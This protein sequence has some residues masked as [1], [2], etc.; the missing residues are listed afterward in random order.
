[1]EFLLRLL[2]AATACAILYG[3][4]TAFDVPTLI[5]KNLNVRPEVLKEI[6]ETVVEDVIKHATGALDLAIGWLFAWLIPRRRERNT[7]TIGEIQTR[8]GISE[9]DRAGL[10]DADCRLTLLRIMLFGTAAYSIAALLATAFIGKLT[11]G[12]AVAHAWYVGLS[13]VAVGFA[14]GLVA[15]RARARTVFA[16][17][18]RVGYV[19][20]LLSQVAGVTCFLPYAASKEWFDLLG[21]FP[22]LGEVRLLNGLLIFRLIVLP[23]VGLFAAIFGHQLGSIAPKH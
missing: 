21:T 18:A 2:V 14:L 1:M 23:V 8:P 16:N 13:F 9:N 19:A 17:A 20:A 12:N 5:L 15:E 3:I 22:V 6:G 7:P 11:P 10:G 4:S